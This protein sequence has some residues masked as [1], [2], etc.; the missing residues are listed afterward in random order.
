M[1]SLKFSVAV[2]LVLALATLGSAAVRM[3]HVFGDHMVLQRNMAVP[4]WGWASPG[5][6]V[7][8]QLD[9]EAPLRV[10]ADA[11]GKWQVK[12]PP[13]KAGG[14]HVLKV[15]GE[16]ELTF[17]DVLFGEVWLCSGQSNM[18]FTVASASNAKEAIAEAGDYPEIRH[19]K[20][21]RVTAGFPQDDVLTHWEVSNSS[22]VPGWTAVGYFFAIN[23][24]RELH[25][26]VGLLNSSWG[27]T[28]IEPWVPLEG[29]EAVPSLKDYTERILKTYPSSPTYK[30]LLGDYLHQLAAWM[31]EAKQALEAE[32]VLEPAPAYPD[33]LKPLTDRTHPTA[34]YNAMINPLIPYAI[35]GA[36][37]YQ[38]ESNHLDGMRYVDKTKALLKGW[39]GKWGEGDF[40]YYY[41]QIAPFRYGNESPAILAK[42]WEAQE[43]IEQTIPN[44]GMASTIDIGNLDDIHPRNK[45]EVGRRLALLALANTYGRKGLVCRGPRFK[46]LKLEGKQL[47]VY[48]KD[49]GSGLVSR[50]GK[51]LNWFEIIGP[52]SNWE[53]AKAV[54]EGD[55]V[56]VSSPEVPNPTAVRFAWSKIAVPNLANAEGLPAIPFQAG[57]VP[58]LDFLGKIPQA[59]EYKLVYDLNLDKLGPDFDY[60]VDNSD[61]IKGPIARVAYFLE[62]MPEG[63]RAQYVW[64]SMKAFTQNPKKVGIPTAKSGA[65]FQR[66]VSDLEVISNIKGVR[67]GTGMH[68]NLEFWPN[69]YN[70]SNTAGVPGASSVNWDFGDTPVP[71]TTGYGC[72]QVCN[73]EARQV[74]FAINAWRSGAGAD[75]GIGNHPGNPYDWTFSR[76]AGSYSYKRLRVFVKLR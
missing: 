21:P 38:G 3:P 60:D 11:E 35:R 50:D 62:L 36:L 15:K 76:N 63:G 48:F 1:K 26:P 49:V 46:S 65:H 40:P 42:F 70:P 28:L 13:H 24:S 59:K 71:P 45:V 51:P 66:P 53:P 23:I 5:E 32:R 44:T 75:L 4:V 22:T 30:Q 64:V 54:I 20:V 14:P 8:V 57:E 56:V 31:A 17:Q 61:A 39:R 12:L 19:L 69:N 6:Q 33:E 25:V 27:G 67:T 18:E 7:S 10:T 29:F 47:R 73:W 43:A 72:M 41:V 58:K 55:S 9:S 68:G 52:G 2:L 16:K 34:L 74:V 37:W